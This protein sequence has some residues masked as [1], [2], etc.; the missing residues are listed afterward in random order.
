MSPPPECRGPAPRCHPPLRSGHV[1][2]AP[3]KF[4]GTLTAPQV[5]SH[6][7]AGLRR[8]CPDV[9]V[10]TLPV[11]DGGD[12]T[13]DSAVAAGY[14]RVRATVQGPTGEPISASFAIRGSGSAV[15]RDGNGTTDG[16]ATTGGTGTTDI[17]S[18]TTDA[19]IEA[20]EACGVRRLPGGIAV[21]LTATS[22]GAGELII[23]AIRAGARQIVLGL[24]GV[25]CTDGGAG[26]VEALGGRLL[27]R[28][29]TPL[30]PGEARCASSTGLR[31]LACGRYRA[32]RRPSTSPSPATW[33][34]ACSARTAQ[35][36]CTARRREPRRMM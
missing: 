23:A 2:V 19:I 25:A 20:A 15:T 22:H 17:T 32:R 4:K 21:P 35:R 16:N 34:V 14:H 31:S 3:D 33:T 26:L 11:A 27:D 30:P 7:A 9:V 12:G 36:P 1:V 5:A 24:G 10:I 8:A 28:A 6:V 18:T 13:V 29:G